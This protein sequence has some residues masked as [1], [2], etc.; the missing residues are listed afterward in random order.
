MLKRL[1][2][3]IQ[4]PASLGIADQL[5]AIENQHLNWRGPWE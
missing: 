5:S 1:R 3:L 4:D 2:Q